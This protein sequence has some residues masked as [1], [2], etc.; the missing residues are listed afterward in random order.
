MR[1]PFGLRWMPLVCFVMLFAPTMTHA[2]DST[3]VSGKTAADSVT[4]RGKAP[5]DSTKR[6]ENV[7][8]DSTKSAAAIDSIVTY[9][10]A[11]SIVYSLSNRE[12]TL[13]DKGQ[14]QYKDFKLNAGHVAINWDT[15]ILT[16]KGV[17]DTSNKMVQEPI[18]TQA[19]ETYDGSKMEYDF[20]SQKGRVNVANTEIDNSYYHGELIKK[21]AKNA[22]YIKNGTFTTCGNKNPDYY[23]QSSRMKLELN[24][25]I[26]A[27]PIIMYLDGVPVFALPFGVFPS[28]SGRRSGLITPSFGESANSGRYFDHLGY[29]WAI[30]DYSD[31]TTTLDWYTRGGYDLKAG[32]RYNW[33]YHFNGSIYGAYSDRYSG[34]PGDPYFNAQYPGYTQQKNWDLQFTHNQT[35][36]PSTSIVANVDMSSNNY[37][38]QTTTP[39]INYGQILQQNLVS[40]VTLFKTWGGSGNSLSLNIHRDQNLNTGAISANLPDITFSHSQSYPFRSGAD[41]NKPPNQ[42]PWYALIGYSYNGQFL[43]TVS[44]TMNVTPV[45]STSDTSFTRSNLY[46]LHHSIS[47]TAAPKIG[48]I[49]LSPFVS[50]TDNMYTARQIATGEY[51]SSLNQDSVAYMTEHGFYNVG[52]FNAGATA[53]TRLFGLMQPNIFGITAFRHVFQPSLTFTYQ[54]DFSKPYWGYYGQYRSLSGYEVPYGFY[55]N[56]IFGGPAPGTVASLA[57]DLNNNFEMKVRSSDTSNTEKK[58]QLL[59]LTADMGYNFA[60]D[61]MGLSEL[62]INYRTNIAGK[63]DIGGS[64]SWNFYQY[65]APWGT[66]IN[67]FLLSEGKLPD[68]TNFQL[69]ISTSFSGSSKSKQSNQGEVQKQDSLKSLKQYNTFYNQM[70][71]PNLNIPWNLSLNLALG[72]SNE[73]PT[74]ETKYA[75]LQ[76]N[77]GFNLTENWKIGFTGGY[78]LIQHQVTVPTVT[79]YR[80]LHCWEMYLTWNP[81]GYYRGFNFEIR[82]KAPQLQDIKI[83]KRENAIVGY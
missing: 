35:I 39:T 2:Q 55:Q 43:N 52:F 10:A 11:D 50:I 24:N 4:V 25:K 8:A 74:Q 45:D 53:S 67:R 79:V 6:N 61:S 68:L 37:F 28:K 34:E 81:I 78:D 12:M 21:Y 7:V 58:V 41:A 40:D 29:F 17:K 36:D 20:K 38:R 59:N 77:L 47:I 51:L 56:S 13:Y 80:D 66:R 30:N 69:N 63:F 31:L 73:I 15:S 23:F 62:S 75:N 16:A 22:M 72:I 57:L 60:A 76:F 3:K 42:L 48:Y 19:G 44:K 18:F 5:T 14:L 9:S 71:R 49:T 82:I 1:S 83:T 46:G 64:N 33:R 54:P 32:F 70:T 65:Y 26:V 27:E